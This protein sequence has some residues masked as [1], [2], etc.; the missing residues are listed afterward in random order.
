MVEYH[1]QGNQYPELAVGQAYEH[2]GIPKAYH[3]DQSP[4][5]IIDR[6]TFELERL[7]TS[8]LAPWQKI[9]ALSTFILPKL[10]FVLRGCQVQKK[11][12]NKVRK[13]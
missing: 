2:F 9:D 8:S 10:S 5:N 6:M 3:V 1:I 11:V 13:P 7:D 12:Q 4:E